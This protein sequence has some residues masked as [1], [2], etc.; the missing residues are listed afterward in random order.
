MKESNDP[1]GLNEQTGVE[2]ALIDQPMVVSVT[3]E[4]LE[5]DSIQ[6]YV[7]S[8][9]RG[10]IASPYVAGAAVLSTIGGLLFGTFSPAGSSL[11]AHLMVAL[12]FRQSQGL[13][14]SQHFIV[15]TVFR[16]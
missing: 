4:R 9:F 16:L 6:P 12:L 8:G 15:L 13:K 14:Y 5:E 7:E 3:E 1:N 10:I 2:D 11:T